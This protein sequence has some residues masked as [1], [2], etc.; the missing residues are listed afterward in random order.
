MQHALLYL[1]GVE[2]YYTHVSILNIYCTLSI[3]LMPA[4]VLHT[5]TTTTFQM[6][7]MLA[8]DTN[9]D[10]VSESVTA[11]VVAEA[12][13]GSNNDG[14]SVTT[15]HSNKTIQKKTRFTW[16]HHGMYPKFLETYIVHEK[17]TKMQFLSVI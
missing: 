9:D 12:V 11:I 17:T 15:Q 10:M 13:D 16:S 1:L 6:C 14:T 3:G 8:M 4:L 2:F 7:N 5:F